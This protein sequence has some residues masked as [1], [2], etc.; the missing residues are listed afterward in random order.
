VT[1]PPAPGGT[2]VVAIDG[3]AGAGKS[4]VG[5]RLAAELKF[6]YLDSGAMYRAVTLAAMRR[7]VP[8][9]DGAALTAL[10]RGLDLDLG[11]DGRVTLGGEDVTAHLRTDAINAGVSSVAAV[12]EVR[13]VMVRHQRRFA[14]QNPRIVAEGRDMGTVVF[15]DAKA[16]LYLDAAPGERARRR[17][18]EGGETVRPEDLARVQASQ[19]RRDRLD[20]TRSVAPLQQAPDAQYVDTTGLTLDQVVARA[21]ERVQSALRLADGG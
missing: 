12:P 11:A 2:L 14:D 7:A 20:S 16:K 9:T 19:E 1:R 5:R 15:P 3:P 6:A 17:A 18:A 10:A 21:M 13:A 4:T 8:L